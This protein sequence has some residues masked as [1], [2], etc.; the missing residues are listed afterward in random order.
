MDNILRTAIASGLEFP[1]STNIDINLIPNNTFGVFVGIKRS[2]KHKLNVWPFDVHGCLGYWNPN[3]KQMD[4]SIVFEKIISLAHLS[5]WTDKRQKHFP[6]TIYVDLGAKYKIYFM[7]ESVMKIDSTNGIII[8][9][10]ETFDNKNYGL[11]VE[12]LNNS[13]RA[14]YLPN[15]FPNKSWDFI[16][17]SFIF[18]LKL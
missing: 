8:S 3:Y 4:K 2:T 18:L 5:T 11:I 13:K 14:T 1:I 12:D 9:N 17:N 10:S 16:K 6:E 7:M 15:V